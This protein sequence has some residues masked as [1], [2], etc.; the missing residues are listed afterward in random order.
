M[1]KPFP[2]PGTRVGIYARFST[3]NQTYESIVRQVDA[4]RKFAEARGWT[5]VGIWEDCERSGTTF[6]GRD[7]FFQ[8]MASA[9]RGDFQ[10]L[11]VE[12]LSRLSRKS[13]DTH[14]LFDDLNDLDISICTVAGGR[15]V[16]D[17]DVMVGA[18]K[19]SKDVA[20]AAYRT[21]GGQALVVESGRSAG[22]I[23]F[24][25]RKIH[26]PDGKNGFREIDPVNGEIARRV[27]EDTANGL[28]PKEI[29]AA[30]TKEG[31]LGPNGKGWRPGA[32]VG[33][34]Q[35]GGGIL[36]N[37]IYIGEI[38]WGR[39]ERKKRKGKITYKPA[40]LSKRIKTVDPALAIVEPE[41]F[42]CV[43]R[44]LESK[45]GQFFSQK[46]ATYVFSGKY[47]CGLCN[48]TMIVLSGKLAC[49]GRKIKGTA[50]RNVVRVPREDAER[51]I[52]GGLSMHLLQREFIEPCVQ[53]Y[54][55]EA[56][57]AAAAFSSRH[58]ANAGRLAEVA[59]QIEGLWPMINDP[60]TPAFAKQALLSQLDT[61]EAQ[62]QRLDFEVRQTPPAEHSGL[63]AGEI[64]D[65]L[66]AMLDDIPQNLAGEERDAVIARDIVRSM[67][68]TIV[69]L[70]D[71][72]TSD[73]RGS[74]KVHLRVDGSLTRLLDL[75][76]VPLER[77]IKRRSGPGTVLHVANIPYTFTT[78]FTYVSERLSGV[79]QVLPPIAKLL[80]EAQAPIGKASFM[81]ALAPPRAPPRRNGPGWSNGFGMRSTT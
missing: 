16:E 38:N 9:D 65:R 52:L 18:Y 57:R 12:D 79:L 63:D 59:G 49:T 54:R 19:N 20:E 74:G 11:L 55:M 1:S 35:L 56:E 22:S 21:R 76:N 33:G 78:S 10:V 77:D 31:H 37:R 44:I 39:T 6:I 27:F 8:M 80:D 71:L 25:Y 73:R 75:A 43:Q 24:G 67:V 30:L 14:T 60:V 51:A 4:A 46:K 34:K 61:L 26:R 15:L 36:R 69:V 40:A 2:P 50:C 41:L 72:T 17:V 42:D 45:N 13:G 47:R 81:A 32:L 28:S 23:P 70:P 7:G 53:A 5:V 29:C 62:R 66:K 58:Q 68:D 3:N 64:V 48:E